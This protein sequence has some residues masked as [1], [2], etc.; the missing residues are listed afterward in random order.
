MRPSTRSAASSLSSAAIR[1]AG[2]KPALPT[3]LLRLAQRLQLGSY[4]A[5]PISYIPNASADALSSFV[6]AQSSWLALTFPAESL[7]ASASGASVSGA[8][9]LATQSIQKDYFFA[10]ASVGSFPLKKSDVLTPDALVEVVYSN[11]S[12]ARGPGFVRHRALA[13]DPVRKA[14]YGV[15]PLWNNA[16][17]AKLRLTLEKFEKLS[18]EEQ[19]AAWPSGERK[20]AFG[21]L[22]AR[23][24]LKTGPFWFVTKSLNGENVFV[25]IRGTDLPGTRPDVT[26]VGLNLNQLIDMSVTWQG[27][28]GKY[29]R[30]PLPAKLTSAAFPSA[31]K[32]DKLW[33]VPDVLAG[34]GAEL[35]SRAKAAL[36][37][38]ELRFALGLRSSRLDERHDLE[39]ACDWREQLQGYDALYKS[40]IIAQIKSWLQQNADVLDGA[41]T[42]TLTGHSLGGSLALAVH[43]FLTQAINDDEPWLP[44]QLK[45]IFR[46]GTGQ[47]VA[48][49]PVNAWGFDDGQILGSSTFNEG[50]EADA[51]AHAV[52]NSADPVGLA[53]VGAEISRRRSLG[54]SVPGGLNEYVSKQNYLASLSQ[55][56]PRGLYFSLFDLARPVPSERLHA[57]YRT[58]VADFEGNGTSPSSTDYFGVLSYDA[59]TKTDVFKQSHF[60][61]VYVQQEQVKAERRSEIPDSLTLRDTYA[62]TDGVAWG[63]AADSSDFWSRADGGTPLPQVQK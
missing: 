56:L 9:L 1:A 35:N 28:S 22:D 20:V 12:D 51:T 32:F 37:G 23:Q 55:S 52:F 13:N 14:L 59:V 58:V 36:R 6:A 63:D 53:W 29:L 62:P 15:T 43:A 7:R 42:L 21:E 54:L 48:F 5:S 11:A 33:S 31:S 4:F 45:V 57:Y 61:G 44:S 17:P 38:H 49:A 60:A 46:A 34:F 8:S 27:D 41:R 3:P 24:S 50:N 39:E 16:P 18:T 30:S 40:E 2:L 10:P 47:T 25:A 19:A 26:G